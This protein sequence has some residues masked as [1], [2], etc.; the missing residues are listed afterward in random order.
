MTDHFDPAAFE[1]FER[2]SWERAADAYADG[3][4]MLSVHTVEPLLDSVG[5][6]AGTRLLDV[7]CGPGVLTR[8][9][10]ERGC[11]VTGVDSA[12]PMLSIARESLPAATFDRADVQAGLPYAD[13]SFD[14]V[15]G[16]M[17]IHHLARPAEAL[18]HLVRVLSRGG[19]LGLTLW[20]PPADNPAQGIFNLAAAAV[21]A[22]PPPGLP[23]LPPRPDDDALEGLFAD[24]NLTGVAVT[25]LQSEFS[26]DPGRWWTA[27]M[28][29]TVLSAALV[30]TQ[31]PEVQGEIRAAYD[32]LVRRYLDK[33]GVATFPVSATLAVGTR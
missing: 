24:A 5:A 16:N 18:G 10:L 1:A 8:R 29:S 32:D 25:H 33:S 20:D 17:V 26:C 11:L 19:R 4:A 6:H 27:V 2:A 14:A 30:T 23:V 31:P 3:F 15:A 12:E 7:G 28:T 13:G 21:A 22:S 9:A